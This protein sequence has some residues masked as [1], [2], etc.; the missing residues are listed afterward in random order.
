MEKN[1]N[2]KYNRKFDRFINILSGLMV[3]IAVVV[4]IMNISTDDEAKTTNVIKNM[5]LTEGQSEGENQI[6]GISLD[7]MKSAEAINNAEGIQE[8]K[9][10]SD[11][12]NSESMNLETIDTEKSDTESSG[13][14][15][16]QN[17]SEEETAVPSV[18]EKEYNNVTSGKLSETAYVSEDYFDNTLFLGDSRTVAL[19]ANGFIRGENTFAVNGISH[20]TFLTQQFTDSVTGVTGDIFSIVKERKPDK[21]YVAL[22]VNGVAYIDKATFISRYEE[23]I[24]GLIAA[25]PESKII[26]QCILPVDEQNYTGGN[27]NLNNTNI[28]N[29]NEELLSLAERKGVFYLDIAY[30]IKDGSNN[31]AQVYDCGD[32]LHFSFTGYSTV[33][34]G[35]CKHGVD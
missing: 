20:V 3:I 26:I 33:Y 12:L 11:N 13:E 25:S 22:G 35:I 24:D 4:I 8:E 32:G 5:D 15:N 31:L 1:Q 28:D 23:L 34:D 7:D 29:M 27:Q 16:A 18:A 10:N 30:L 6:A 17:V 21:I 14:E 9:N 2:Y 19:Q